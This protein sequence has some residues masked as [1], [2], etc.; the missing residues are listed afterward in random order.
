MF[1]M[2]SVCHACRHRSIPHAGQ[3]Y[4]LI[5]MARRVPRGTTTDTDDGYR[6]ERK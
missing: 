3:R 2:S 4:S 6:G 1:A 5:A